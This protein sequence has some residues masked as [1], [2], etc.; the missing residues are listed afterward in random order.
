MEIE[1][2]MVQTEE[3]KGLEEE[4]KE[5]KD[6]PAAQT[7]EPEKKQIWMKGQKYRKP[8]NRSQSVVA[9]RAY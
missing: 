4:N 6:D 2:S 5:P 3:S 8:K 9:R 7:Y 1:E